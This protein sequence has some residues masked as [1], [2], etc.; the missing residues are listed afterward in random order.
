MSPNVVALLYLAAGVLFILALRGLSSPVSSRR[1]NM[2]GMAGMT[3]AVATTLGQIGD[4]DSATL[5]D[6]F[7]AARELIVAANAGGGTDNISVIVV[8]AS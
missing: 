2:L 6:P 8:Y 3:I 7:D 5:A 1:G 4:P